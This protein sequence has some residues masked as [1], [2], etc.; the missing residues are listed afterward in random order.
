MILVTSPSKPFL[1]NAKGTPRRNVI[2][3]MY[4]DEIEALYKQVEDSAQGDLE[5][6]A[7]WDEEG[8]RAFVR[9]V[10]EHTLRRSIADDADIFR[11][12]GD[13]YG[14]TCDFC[15]SLLTQGSIHPVCKP[16]GSAT[17]SCGRSARKTRARRDASP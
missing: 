7:A 15:A 9:A 3:G 5:P 12:G 1:L 2:L 13:R 8:T 6:P 14:Y 11:N 4:N 10:V 16:L 17:R